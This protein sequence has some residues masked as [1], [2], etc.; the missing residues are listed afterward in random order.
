MASVIDYYGDNQDVIIANAGPGHWNDPDMVR[1]LVTY[2]LLK[3]CNTIMRKLQM[4]SYQLG[5]YPKNDDA[6]GVEI[7]FSS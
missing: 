6:S 1:N 4:V 5:V 3:H 2:E 7:I